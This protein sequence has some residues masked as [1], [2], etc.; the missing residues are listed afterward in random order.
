L[1]KAP[2]TYDIYNQRVSVVD[3][4][5]VEA[6]RGL[7]QYKNMFGVLRM[8]AGFFYSTTNSF[9]EHKLVYDWVR[10]QIRVSFK[11]TLVKGGRDDASKVREGPQ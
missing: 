6:I 5:G 7:E 11:I 2:P 3:P 1:L 10:S 9:I 4:S 8:A